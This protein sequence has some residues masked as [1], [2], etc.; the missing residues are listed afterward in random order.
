[1]NDSAIILYA[2]STCSHC[3][4]VKALLNEKDVA[5]ECIYVDQL[6][7]EERK[8]V[9]AKVKAF[10]ERLTFPTTVIGDTVIIGNKQEELK[11]ALSALKD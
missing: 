9:I 2:L 7:G 5:Y 6:A 10:N 3:K 4:S 1:M 11:K 8:E